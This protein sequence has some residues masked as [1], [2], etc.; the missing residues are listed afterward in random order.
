MIT[1][2]TTY[3]KTSPNG[4]VFQVTRTVTVYDANE[5]RARRHSN[6]RRTGNL[7]RNMRYLERKTDYDPFDFR[8]DKA[9][10][11]AYEDYLESTRY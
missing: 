3:L 8:E 1:K 6:D 9:I 11:E 10:R 5:R 7:V 4:K 2:T